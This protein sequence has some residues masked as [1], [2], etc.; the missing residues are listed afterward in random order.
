MTD[1]GLVFLGVIALATLVMALI[2]VAVFVVT[3]RLAK[4]AQ[5]AVSKAQE[6]LTTAQQT[7]TSVREEIRPLIASAN[8]IAEEASRAATLATA[9]VHK[10]DR[11]V[12]DLTARVDETSALVQQAII[13]PVNSATAVD[14]VN[15]TFA[16]CER[17]RR[18]RESMCIK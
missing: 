3:A 7:M 2:Q 11:L 17:S 15:N 18:K 12:S 16:G 1:W 4:Q 14:G 10:V 8:G 6:T 13:T 9:Q 5:Q